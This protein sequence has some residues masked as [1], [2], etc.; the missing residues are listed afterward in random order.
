[1]MVDIQKINIG[2]RA[3]DGTGDTLRNAFSKAND[4]FEALNTVPEKG[5]KGDKGTKGDAG[6][7]G[8]GIKTITASKEGNVVT[9]TVELT[10]GTRQTPSFEV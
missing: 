1:M 6:V 2:T 4:N 8:V 9:L 3:D 5:D 10:D 7:A